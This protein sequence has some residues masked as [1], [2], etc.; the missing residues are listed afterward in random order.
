[1]MIIIKI[2]TDRILSLLNSFKIDDQLIDVI[3]SIKKG[4]V[5]LGIDYSDEFMNI[6]VESEYNVKN[7]LRVKKDFERVKKILIY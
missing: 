4:V 3:V 7:T 1:M 2:L 5:I 6:P